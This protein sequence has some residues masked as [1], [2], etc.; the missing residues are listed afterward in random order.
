MLR[1]LLVTTV[2]I[3]FSGVSAFGIQKVDLHPTEG[4]FSWVSAPY[5]YYLALQESLI[6][7]SIYRE[8]QMLVV[9]SFEPEWVVYLV[10]DDKGVAHVIYKVMEKSLW[11]NM[12][13]QIEHDAVNPNSYS[14]GVYA[15]SAALLKLEKKVE[16]HAAPIGKAAAETLNNVWDAMLTRVKYPLEPMLGLDGAT[17]YVAHWTQSKGFRSGT[18]RSPDPKSLA[19][20]LVELGD[21]LRVFSLALPLEQPV[22]EKD[23]LASARALYSKIGKKH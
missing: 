11:G 15:Q 1:L 13:G 20:A 14:T 5:P 10:R 8:C 17:Y 7:E 22:L 12:M 3:I 6:G 21:K 9:P 23:I 4:V 18:T 2:I 19:G 16:R